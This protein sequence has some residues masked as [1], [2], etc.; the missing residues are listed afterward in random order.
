MLRITAGVAVTCKE[1]R[2]IPVS[3]LGG[4]RDLQ[5]W[6]LFWPNTLQRVSKHLESFL[7]IHRI[8]EW[9]ELEG[10]PRGHLIQIPCN[11]QGHPQP[12]RVPTC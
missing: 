8:V 10:I 9:F 2:R 5:N 3:F 12:P 1:R 4:P 11:E 7:L 6:L